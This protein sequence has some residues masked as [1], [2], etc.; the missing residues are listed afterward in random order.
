MGF[1]DTA[2]KIG[3][4]ALLA[5]FT[6]GAAAYKLINKGPDEDDLDAKYGTGA[7][8][9]MAAWESSAGPYT[10]PIDMSGFVPSNPMNIGQEMEDYANA[11]RAAGAK[12][13]DQELFSRAGTEA[14]RILSGYDKRGIGKFREEALREGPSA[15]NALAKR[16]QG[17][18][19]A[20]GRERAGAESAGRAAEAR[21]GLAMR[22]GLSSGARE[23][24]AKESGRDFLSMSQD[25]GRDEAMSGMQIDM[26]DEQNRMQRLGMLPGMEVQALAPEFEGLAAQE[27][28]TE[29]MLREAQSKRD[30]AMQTYA[31]KMKG[32][33]A[34]QQARATEEGG[35]GGTLFI[36][37]ALKDMGLMSPL[38][39]ARML[40]F[41]LKGVVTRADFFAWYLRKG[42]E[43]VEAAKS[44]K[45][46][47]GSVKKRFVDDILAAERDF[48]AD[49]ARS[50][51][52]E[53][54]GEFVTKFLGAE[55]AAFPKSVARPGL[56]KALVKLP[57]VFTLPGTWGWLFKH[58]GFRLGR[59]FRKRVPA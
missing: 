39:S 25:I 36:C 17:A 33:A 34:N 1:W 7:Q 51:Y 8:P 30:Y 21:S 19:A 4:G 18:Q 14:K 53:R 43:A 40:K 49:I 28:D 46:D 3:K 13:Q 37:T 56:A 32:Y 12:A 45:V 26:S 48:G 35:G 5:P 58:L 24:L 22:G 15:W 31:E 16:A 23:R 38:E 44:Q 9:E 27:R 42:G 2:G 20:A 55:K 41:M 59:A 47:W 52:A 57:L 10:G 50:L 11:Q 29:R 54:A 6:G